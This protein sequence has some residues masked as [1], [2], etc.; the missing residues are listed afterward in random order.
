[1][2]KRVNISYLLSTILLL[3]TGCE[4][5]T[6]L[7]S[8]PTDGEEP[9]EI[10]LSA[11]VVQVSASIIT[12]SD[13]LNETSFKDGTK[14]VGVFG[15]QAQ[16]GSFTD[17]PYV[18]NFALTNNSDGTLSGD[19]RI[20]F[21]AGY[22][23]ITAYLYGYYPYTAEA[24]LI[25][26]GN[27]ILIP[28]KSGLSGVADTKW[29]NANTDPLHATAAPTFER[30]E[31]AINERPSIPVT[32]NFRHMMAQLQIS[33]NTETLDKYR[34]QEII[35]TF[36]KHQHGYMNVRNGEI[37]S[38]NPDSEETCTETFPDEDF[39]GAATA[40]AQSIHSALPGDNAIRKIEVKIKIEGEENGRV[41]EAFNAATAN[42]SINLTAGSITAVTINFN[43]NTTAQATLDDTWNITE[44]HSF[45]YTD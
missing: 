33:V 41:Y 2:S 13:F 20:Y 22:G 35:T 43:P 45:D 5:E 17:Y 27:D 29:A 24:G 25:P 6:S 32:L 34:L 18:N 23:K 9:V 40:T 4:Q 12:R 39:I 37:T 14:Q 26:Q 1:M 8:S 30:V 11:N 36:S 28:V 44:E 38:A 31:G 21:P 10:L 16:D 42:K 19:G 3:L 7:V 15:L